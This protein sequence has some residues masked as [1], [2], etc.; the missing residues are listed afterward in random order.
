MSAA[1]VAADVG[2]TRT[3][4]EATESDGEAA[5]EP[6]RTRRALGV[7]VSAVDA[8]ASALRSLMASASVVAAV[9]IWHAAEM[10]SPTA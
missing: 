7:A 6:R 4:S 10:A 2:R 1:D 3:A 8:V 5:P 9:L